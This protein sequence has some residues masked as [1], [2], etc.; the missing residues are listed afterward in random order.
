M[1]FQNRVFQGLTIA[2]LVV[3]LSVCKGQERFTFRGTIVDAETGQILPAR[4]YIQ[5]A[6]GSFFFPRSTDGGSA[7]E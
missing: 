3:V 7:V 5:S 4:V 1:N 6:E 2:A